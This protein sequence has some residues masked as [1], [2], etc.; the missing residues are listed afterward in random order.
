MQAD[1][2]L[3]VIPLV[4]RGAPDSNDSDCVSDP[5]ERTAVQRQLGVCP[6]GNGCFLKYL[7]C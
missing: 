5:L 3:A 6:E 4:R 1:Q 2:A 7:I